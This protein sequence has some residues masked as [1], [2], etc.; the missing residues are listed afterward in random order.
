MPRW[1]VHVDRPDRIEMPGPPRRQVAGEPRDGDEGCRH[2]DERG[3]INCRDA[4]QQRGQCARDGQGAGEADHCAQ[5]GERQ[6]VAEQSRRGLRRRGPQCNGQ[7]DFARPLLGRIRDRPVKAGVG[8]RGLSALLRALPNFAARANDAAH[9]LDSPPNYFDVVEQSHAF[10]GIAAYWSPA[11]I[12]PETVLIRRNCRRRPGSV[13]IRKNAESRRE[14]VLSP[15]RRR[16]GRNPPLRRLL[17]R[18]GELD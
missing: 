3:G 10:T 11:S 15:L 14:A 18:V 5:G 12:S 9:P 17:E 16:R 13:C 4:E 2:G 6:P 1:S 7:A 8:Y